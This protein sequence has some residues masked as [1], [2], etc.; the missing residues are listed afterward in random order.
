MVVTGGGGFIGRRLVRSLLEQGRRVRVI[1]RRP[2]APEGCEHVLADLVDDDITDALQG[3]VVFHLAGRAGV[4]GDDAETERQRL[5]DNVVATERVVRGTPK[6][7]PLVFASSSSVYG[8]TLGR[9][10]REDGP[11]APRGGYA[12]SKLVAEQICRARA[13]SGGLVHTARLFTVVGEGQR[14]DMALALWADAV[15][16]GRPVTV[17][18]DLNRSRDFTDV[19]QAVDVLIRLSSVRSPTVVNVGTGVRQT[20]GTLLEAIGR[21]LGRQPEIRLVDAPRQDPYATLA[22]TTRLRML[23]DGALLTDLVDVVGRYLMEDVSTMPTL[24]E[25]QLT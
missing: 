20:V 16:A 14:P 18:G 15:A 10:C 12:W 22:D 5:R 21:Q 7:V 3:D 1:D 2:G 19:A 23:A 8:G 4:R 9:P 24:T 17:Y 25:G 13:F 11:L 6:D